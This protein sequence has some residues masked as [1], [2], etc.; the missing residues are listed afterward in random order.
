MIIISHR[1]NLNGPDNLK[2]N[3]PAQIDECINRKIPVEIDVWVQNN[4]IYLGHDAPVVRIGLEFILDRCHMLFVHCKNK[5]AF[6][7]FLDFPAVNCFWHQN[8]DYTL[9]SKRQ[10]WTYPRKVTVAKSIIV[11]QTESETQEYLQKPI[12]GICTDFVEFTLNLQQNK[13]EA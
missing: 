8:D 13:I 10:I 3:T 5:E 12:M 4:S 11:C 6:E 7:Y 2:E 9:T 1:G